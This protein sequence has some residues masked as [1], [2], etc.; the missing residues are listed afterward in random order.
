SR[1]PGC[2]AALR[3]D[4]A[5]RVG[6]WAKRFSIRAAPAGYHCA[7][8]AANCL[9]LPFGTVG[10]RHKKASAD[11]AELEAAC[12]LIAGNLGAGLRAAHAAH[13]F[14][15]SVLAV[16]P[17]GREPEHRSIVR[18]HF[19]PLRMP[20]FA[21]NAVDSRQVVTGHIEQQMMLEVIVHVIR[22]DEQPLE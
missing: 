2:Q 10:S 17:G 13:E 12:G 6:T 9:A 16:G 19:H 7:A 5:A 15:R 8:K 14:A 21:E 18:L 22:R 4:P 20:A 1:R 11:P 3:Y